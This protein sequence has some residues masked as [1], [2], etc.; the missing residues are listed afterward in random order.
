MV[1]TCVDEFDDLGY[2]VVKMGFVVGIHGNLKF[3]ML[4]T[5]NID[6]GGSSV[7]FQEIDKSGQVI[8]QIF[9]FFEIVEELSQ[10]RAVHSKEKCL[11]SSAENFEKVL[12]QGGG[13]EVGTVALLGT[14]VSG[15]H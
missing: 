6:T 13:K 8:G 10:K 4:E 12:Y 9:G 3:G 11:V 2:L 5:A 1:L 7:F 14:V 15:G